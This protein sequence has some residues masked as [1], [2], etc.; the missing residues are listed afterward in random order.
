[1]PFKIVE[2]IERGKPQLSIVPSCWEKK[3]LL[4]WPPKKYPINK[5]VTNE[6]SIPQ[7][8]WLTIKCVL[9]R[10][11]ILSYSRAEEE[12]DMMAQ[13]SDTSDVNDDGMIN[14]NNITNYNNMAANL[15]SEKPYWTH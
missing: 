2:T 6:N 13:Y 8:D 12:I 14:T 11:S 1:M 3:G 4:R 5:L 15:V 10:T 7:A 9:K